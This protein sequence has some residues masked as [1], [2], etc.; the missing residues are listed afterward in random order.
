MIMGMGRLSIVFL[1][2]IAS[3]L[4]LRTIILPFPSSA[5]PRFQVTDVMK[6][7]M[8]AAQPAGELSGQRMPSYLMAWALKKAVAAGEMGMGRWWGRWLRKK[9]TT[10]T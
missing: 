2:I 1:L 10:K 4:N 9:I 6:P 5:T 3:Y 8:L 7:A